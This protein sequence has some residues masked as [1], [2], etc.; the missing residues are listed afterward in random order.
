MRAKYFPDIVT[1]DC[2]WAHEGRKPSLISL[3]KQYSPCDNFFIV[4]EEL[5]FLILKFFVGQIIIFASI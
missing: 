5:Y 1:F 3:I 2:E 4:S